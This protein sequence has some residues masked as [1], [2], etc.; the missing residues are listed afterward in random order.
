[1]GNIFD[2]LVVN[3]M[4]NVLL[5]IYDVLFHNYVLAIIVLTIIIRLATLPL[6]LKQQVSSL[7]MAAMQ[8]QIK[9]IQEKYKNDPQKLSEEMRKVGFNPLGGCLPLLIQFPI[10][11]GLYNAILRTLAVTPISL[12]EL[13]KHIYGFLPNLS[14]LV[15]VN[16]TFLGV[17]DLGQ[18]DKLFIIPILV[19]ATT[20]FSTKLTTP[21][22]TD[23]TSKQTNQMM[24]MMMPVMFGF[25]MLSAP[26]GLGVYWIVS[27]LI[28]IGQYYLMKPRLDLA[29]AEHA[30]AAAGNALPTSVSTP[31]KP[32]AKL[33]PPRSKVKPSSSARVA[34]PGSDN[35]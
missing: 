31:A 18:P 25:F 13:G 22:S 11:I 21:P 19:I 10:L 34:K 27:N 4:T 5:L 2:I 8:P 3:P 16:S 17:L 32:K 26:A 20:Y 23:A 6:T 9:A 7:K 33:P 15:P 1:M 14:S 30:A 28:G 35:K 24:S 29:K 12:L